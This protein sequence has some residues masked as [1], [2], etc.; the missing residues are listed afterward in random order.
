VFK[1]SRHAPHAVNSLKVATNTKRLFGNKLRDYN[2]D[3]YKWGS[4]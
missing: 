2:P 3:F 4:T 1:G